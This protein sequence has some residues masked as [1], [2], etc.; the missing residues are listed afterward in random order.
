LIGNKVLGRLAPMDEPNNKKVPPMDTHEWAVRA[1][2]ELLRRSREAVEKE[3][4]RQEK[5]R[6]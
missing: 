2:I 3:L 4:R 1:L 6:P 5:K